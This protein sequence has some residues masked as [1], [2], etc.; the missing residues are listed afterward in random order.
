MKATATACANLALIKYWGKRDAAQNI[1]ANDSVSVTL[2]GLTATTT[3]EFDAALARDEI[4][5]NGART[6]DARIRR[7]LDHVRRLAG[8]TDGARVVTTTTFPVR[9]GLASSAAGM[10]ALSAAAA[11]AARLR[12]D[13]RALSA[14]ARLGSGSAARS[15]HGGFV[16][17]HAGTDHASSFAEPLARAD[18]LDLAIAAVVLT[19]TPKPVESTEAMERTQATSPLYP[20]RL[21]YV[22]GA[23]DRLTLA[24]HAGDLPGVGQ[25]AELDALNLHACMMTT[26]PPLLFWVP[27]TVALLH[28]VWAHRERTGRTVYFSIDAGANVFLLGSPDE[29][30]RA[31]ASLPTVARATRVLRSRPGPGVEYP[32]KHLF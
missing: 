1:P 21:A 26:D 6:E 15:I 12:L 11:R 19:E 8:T 18:A 22:E 2:D 16:H 10:A 13:D 4:E 25:I 14:L 31:L 29:I 3:V 27:E 7:Q 23:I 5:L 32:S 24:L 28:D 30:E 9:A 20:A 17:W